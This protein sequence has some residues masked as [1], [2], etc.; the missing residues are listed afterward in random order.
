MTTT[1]PSREE[2]GQAGAIIGEALTAPYYYGPGVELAEDREV[3]GS[4]TRSCQ[5]LPAFTPGS[6]SPLSS[7]C[8]ECIRRRSV[9]TDI[10]TSKRVFAL[11]E[12]I[13]KQSRRTRGGS[14]GHQG[15]DPYDAEGHDPLA[16]LFVLALAA[17][18]YGQVRRR[19]PR[20][21]QSLHKS[22]LNSSDAFQRS[23]GRSPDPSFSG[24]LRRAGLSRPPRIFGV[25]SPL[26]WPAR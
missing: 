25:A 5:S 12:I 16:V 18:W 8:F 10:L 2:K 9:R 13:L 1:R 20:S 7:N 24:I 22:H 17:Q 15:R 14:G 23:Q 21:K 4:L 3:R 26:S 11:H 6:Q 19:C